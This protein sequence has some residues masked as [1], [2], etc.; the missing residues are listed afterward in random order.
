MRKRIGV[1][2]AF[3]SPSSLADGRFQE[4]EEQVVCVP[5]ISFFFFFASTV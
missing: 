1:W 4:E 2:R 5:H 3:P